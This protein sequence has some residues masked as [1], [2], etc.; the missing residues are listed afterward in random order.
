MT[1]FRQPGT[2]DGI[3]GDGT[4]T[5][6]TAVYNAWDRLVQVD[7]QR[8]IAQYRYD[9]AGR[10]T[11]E[12]TGFGGGRRL[13]RSRTILRTGSRSSRPATAP[14]GA[15]AKGLSP[16]YQYVW[17]A[18]GNNSLILRD[19]FTQT[20]GTTA[21]RLYYLNDANFNVTSLVGKV[22]APGRLSDTTP[23]IP[24][25]NVTVY[26]PTWATVRASGSTSLE[27]VLF[28]GFALD[29]LNGL[30]QMVRR[31]YDPALAGSSTAIRP[32]CRQWHQPLAYCGDIPWSHG[33]D[34]LV[35][36]RG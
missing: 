20:P 25:G 35:R 23:T 3:P 9:G 16:H 11:E 2:G 6:E 32:L 30:Y 26:H 7:Q 12:L 31:Y 22:C 27:P 8:P 19:D 24:Y 13:P 17:S 29:P 10:M 28:A 21:A 15:P 14:P 18:R 34:R 4:G 33:P 1:A 5:A 36:D